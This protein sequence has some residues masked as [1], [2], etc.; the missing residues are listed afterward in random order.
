MH[1]ASSSQPWT[2]YTPRRGH[3]YNNSASKNT[4]SSRSPV[5][6]EHQHHSKM[7]FIAGSELDQQNPDSLDR[8][9]LELEDDL[10][11]Q[12]WQGRG[13]IMELGVHTQSPRPRPKGEN[14]DLAFSN[15]MRRYI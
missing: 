4:T 1:S 7:T 6:P 10:R 8:Y 11:R 5:P 9:R 2:R 15:T 3:V 13:G 12:Q 14:T